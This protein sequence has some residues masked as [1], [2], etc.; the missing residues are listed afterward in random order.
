MSNE[1]PCCGNCK[2]WQ[3]YSNT[4]GQYTCV[5]DVPREIA[6][7]STYKDSYCG[8]HKFPL[9]IVMKRYGLTYLEKLVEAAED[10]DE[11]ALNQLKDLELRARGQ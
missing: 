4:S 8:K 10:G 11:I 3:G 2:Y 1:K 9:P 6:R 5:V 7:C